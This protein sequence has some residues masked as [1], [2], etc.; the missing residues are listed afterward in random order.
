MCGIFSFLNN[1]N[2]DIRLI[3]K[4]FLKGQNRGPENTQFIDKLYGISNLSIGF[5]RLAINGLN[6]QSNQPIQ[7]GNI[8]LICNGEIYNYKQLYE[9]I[10]ISPKTS[11]DCEIIIHLYKKY[12]IDYTLQLLDGVFA[13]ILFDLDDTKNTL[14]IHAARDSY[15]IRPL[16]IL[17]N[18]QGLS[19]F[20]SELKQLS[21]LCQ[22]E[23]LLTQFPPGRA[24]S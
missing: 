18:H 20:S 22:E 11:S 17:E 8:T 4:Q 5:H 3:Y 21:E 14:K 16:F 24:F 6:E 10:D 23:E 2:K 15:G 19:G 9:T 7:D 1:F 13:F 12:G